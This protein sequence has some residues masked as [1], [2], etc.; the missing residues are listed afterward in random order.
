MPSRK[1]FLFNITLCLNCLL[2]LFV[3]AGDRLHVPSWL[4]V[5]GR[6]H[7]LI[8]H[9]PIVLLILYVTWSI[10]QQGTINKNY[11]GPED[12]LG[13]WLLL[14][15]A[16]TAAITA[17]MGMLLSREGG[18]N[19]EGIALHKWGGVI[20]SLFVFG[21]YSYRNAIQKNKFLSAFS[22]LF[23]FVLIIFTG[24]KGSDITHGENYL[25]APVTP[26][27]VKPVVP[28]EEAVVFK[29]MV[30]PILD[31]KCMSCHSNKKAKGELVM[32][33]TAQLLKGGKHGVLWVSGQPELSLLLQRIHLPEAEKKHM[34][35]IGKPQL[36]DEETAILYQWIKNG[37]NFKQKVS[38]LPLTDSLRI[39]ANNLFGKGENESYSFAAASDKDV[40]KLNN[41][42]RLIHAIAIGSPALAVNFYN[43][44]NY[45]TAAL[46]ELQPIKTQIVELD[47]AYMPLAEADINDIATFANL[48]KL[49]LNFTTVPGKSLTALK[50]LAFLTHLSLSGTNITEKDLET[51]A[52][53]PKLQ[54]VYLWNAPITTQQIAALKKQ[55]EKISFE[56]GFENDTLKLKLNPPVLE[57]EQRIVNVA[58]IAIKMKHYIK[59]AIIRYTTDG[60][61]PDSINSAIYKDSVMLDKAAVFKARAFKSGWYGS[62]SI[63]TTFYKNSFRADSIHSFTPLDSVYKGTNGAYTLIDGI[64]GEG[65][66]RSGKWLGFRRNKMEM[67]L[68]YPQPITISSVTLSSYM[69]VGGYI[70]PPA[71]LEVWGGTTEK[72][73]TRLSHITPHQPDSLNVPSAMRGFD[74]NFKPVTISFLKVIAIPV[75]KLPKWHPGKGQKGWVFT[76]EIFVN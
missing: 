25:L 18:Y 65:D 3:L 42:N 51:V 19:Q 12:E 48:R 55:H 36:D 63:M 66:L 11:K 4:Q 32:E 68:H 75:D 9:F 74:C 39:L 41:T 10:F 21:W 50:S 53:F 37:A 44:Q 58:P 5:A 23:A 1:N 73:M 61:L 14:I 59:G 35:P 57:T 17:V 54:A 72:N 40:E 15:C 7:P 69:N 76:D 60:S 31:A 64:K 22:A 13:R 56:T 34:P 28:L 52:S 8:L 26:E 33:T 30:Q 70:M 29:D 27:K 20:I 71:Q 16:F 24:H 6:M 49:N 45:S 38:E 46:K 43:R 67:L 62:D 2:I 47:L